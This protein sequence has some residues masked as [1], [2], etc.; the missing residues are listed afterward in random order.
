MEARFVE[1]PV[2]DF[3]K[4][5]VDIPRFLVSCK[6]CPNFDKR[7]SCPPFNFSVEA[8]WK[9]YTGILLYEIKIPISR[10]LQE[11]TYA[12]AELN[13]ISREILAPVKKQMTEDLLV[14]EKQNPGSMALFAGTCEI[15]E[16]C[17]KEDGEPCRH[18]EQ[19]RYS[20][21]ALGGNVVQ[22]VQL[23][24]D[25]R[26]LWAAEGR[27]PDYFILLGGLLKP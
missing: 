13:E 27:L 17:D 12:Q 10:D 7:W 19:M 20:I 25:D 4:T 6:E 15:C 1:G 14:M 3:V 26:I 2:S 9:Q 23:F 5:C 21:E 18:P 16:N 24:F 8:I 22:S 11:K